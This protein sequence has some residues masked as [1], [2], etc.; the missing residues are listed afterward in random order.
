MKSLVQA[1]PT[2]LTRL[3]SLF[4][5]PFLCQVR[6]FVEKS[7][8]VVGINIEWQGE[9]GSVNEVGVNSETGEPVV[10]VDERYFRPTE[11]DILIGDP[12]KAKAK[13]GWTPTTLFEDLVKE[14]TL[15]DLALVDK[16][17]TAG[18][19]L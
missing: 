11:V 13:I 12:A 17:L 8:T 16:S 10:K 7:F 1:T 5:S 9:E 3:S 18:E 4:P 14:M 15:A 2:F 6:E 19:D